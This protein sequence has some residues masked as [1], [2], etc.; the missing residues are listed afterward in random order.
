MK[1]DR[2]KKLD[3][4][5]SIPSQVSK[6]LDGV[7][8]ILAMDGDIIEMIHYDPPIALEVLKQANSPLYGHSS[9][10]FSLQQAAELLGIGAIKNVILTT[11]IYERFEDHQTPVIELELTKLWIHSAVT[12]S[13]AGGIG[14]MVDD[15]DPDVCFTVGLIKDCGLIA[16]AM[17]YSE[18]INDI[19]KCQANDKISLFEAEQKVIGIT[20]AEIGASML[21]NWGLP[22]EL[23]ET[24]KNCCETENGNPG[25]KLSGVI[26]LAKFL[27]VSWGYG[28]E[29]QNGLNMDVNP[30]LEAVNLS[31]KEF[32]G[33]EEL[34]RNKAIRAASVIKG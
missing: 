16:L 4:I 5:P 27:A 1:I 29:N 23:S 12:A 22:K 15:L 6:V 14:A 34:L 18:S 30:L 28:C 32:S 24:I 25:S 3:N 26:G 2:F 31:M 13:A 19:M 7:E 17:H 20:H 33:C 8:G 10:I 11:S 9:Q 21:E